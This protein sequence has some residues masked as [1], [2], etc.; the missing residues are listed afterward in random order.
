MT[1]VT[2]TVHQGNDLLWTNRFSFDPEYIVT[3]MQVEIDP[4]Q[5]ELQTKPVGQLTCQFRIINICFKN[6]Y[7]RLSLW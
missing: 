3:I 6:L 4:V 7:H 2:M 1:F 5:W